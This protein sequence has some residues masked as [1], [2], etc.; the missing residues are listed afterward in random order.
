MK[1]HLFYT[2]L[3]IFIATAIVTLC[4][5]T[6]VLSI[7]DE[8]L[9]PLIA[10]LLIEIAV[11]IIGLFRKTEFFS[12][13]IPT[14]GQSLD[15]EKDFGVVQADPGMDQYASVFKHKHIEH[16][17]FPGEELVSDVKLIKALNKAKDL[18]ENER[19][20]EAIAIYKKLLIDSRTLNVLN[21]Y[22]KLLFRTGEVE[23]AE[24]LFDEIVSVATFEGNI[25][26]ISRANANLSLIYQAKGEL[27]KAER[28]LETSKMFNEKLKHK[29]GI[30]DNLRHLADILRV[31]GN[32]I[33]A[34]E[35][36][37]KALELFQEI[38]YDPGSADAC[39]G[40][41]K[42]FKLL[43]DYDASIIYQSGSLELNLE[44]R[45]KSCI[46][47]NYSELGSVYRIQGN[48]SEAES[49]LNEALSMNIAMKRQRGIMEN[50]GRLGLIYLY[51]GHEEKAEKYLKDALDMSQRLPSIEDTAKHIANLAKLEW[52][53]GNYDHAQKHLKQAK[54]LHE[55]IGSENGIANVEF[56]FGGVLL[57]TGKYEDA[58]T[59]VSLSKEIW[60]R[61]GN[62]KG[63]ADCYELL[64]MVY[65]RKAIS[66]KPSLLGKAK[67]FALIAI[68]ESEKIGAM[69][70]LGSATQTLGAILEKSGNIAEALEKYESAKRIFD[71]NGE[72]RKSEMVLKKIA[73]LKM[74]I[75]NPLKSEAVSR[76]C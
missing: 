60:V 26:W 56:I 37:K 65:M 35:E 9:Q 43:G 68:E 75:T 15:G 74:L 7:K 69:L 42:A 13:N 19:V 4:G 66:R 12:E 57:T 67:Q 47:D 6:G 31:R 25:G 59:Q 61:M 1:K 46:A 14:H 8:Y 36:Y 64:A 71:K 34:H 23:E 72:L 54:N 45:R 32:V 39:S 55:Q 28:L 51:Q 76:E 70:T 62:K 20:D 21:D 53:R 11:A 27:N 10:A 24:R 40:L 17:R 50:I 41:G 3:L 38:S 18:A 63:I 29:A 52:F 5:V 49:H 58:E 22:A 2:L 16:I 44:H 48:L 73:S 33:R 30:A